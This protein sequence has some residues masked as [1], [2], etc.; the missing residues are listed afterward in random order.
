VLYHKYCDG[1][2]THF[3]N[4]DW[5]NYLYLSELLN[6]QLTVEVRA[7]LELLM[8]CCLVNNPVRL[9]IAVLFFLD[10]NF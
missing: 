7:V 9:A 8:Q 3:A 2:N 4:P 6:L 1:S 5:W 10:L